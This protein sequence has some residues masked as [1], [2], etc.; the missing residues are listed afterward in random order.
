MADVVKGYT[1][2][3][4]EVVVAVAAVHVQAAHELVAGGHA[5]QHLQFLDHVRRAENGYAG[6]ELLALDVHQARLGGVAHLLPDGGNARGIQRV[7]HL[8]R[9]QAS[10]RYQEQQP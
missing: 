1:V 3:K 9:L 4:E 7:P 8:L 2:Q 6:V 10:R 5:G